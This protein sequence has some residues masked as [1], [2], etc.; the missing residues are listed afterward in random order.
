M[1]EV[2]VHH[3][4]NSC[5]KGTNT[6]RFSFPRLPSDETLIAYP[7][8]ELSSK[9]ESVVFKKILHDVKLKKN[10]SDKDLNLYE[11]DLEEFLRKLSINFDDYK[12]ALRWDGIKKTSDKSKKILE[13]VKQKPTDLTDDRTWKV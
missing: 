3:H 9:E 1:K 2:N 11:Q 6:C 13:K 5:K 8:P 7:I 10:E 12:E 4:T